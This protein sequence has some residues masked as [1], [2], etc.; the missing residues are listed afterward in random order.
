MTRTW[1]PRLLV[2]FFLIAFGAVAV[3]HAWLC[4]DAYIT[5]RTVDNF[6]N[7]Y[8][9]TWNVSERVQV[10]THPLWL[11]LLSAV[12]LFTREAF[13]SSQVLSIAVSLLAVAVLATRVAA[14]RAAACLGVAILAASKAFVDYATSG[15][16]N[17][18]THLILVA[19]FLVYFKSDSRP[20]TLFLLALLAASAML[21]RLDAGL[22]LLPPLVA[23]WARSRQARGLGAVAAGFVPLILWETFSF[24]YYGTLLPNTALAK[25]N[26]GLIGR[27][28]LLEQ[29]WHYLSDSIKVDPVTLSVI[30]AGLALPLARKAWRALP[31]SAGVVLYLVYIVRIGGDFM[32]GRFLTAPL[33][34]AVAI[35]VSGALRLRQEI[36]LATCVPLVVLVLRTP[37]SPLLTS[38]EYGADVP[39]ERWINPYGIAD[40]RAYY[41]PHTG[42]LMA[43]ERAGLP[44]HE[45]AMAGRAARL[46]GPAIVQDMAIGFLGYFAGPRVHVVD[47]LGLADPLLARLPPADPDWRIGHFLRM[48]PDGYV[49]TLT[50]GE[51]RIADENLA[52]YYDVLARVTRGDLFDV[53]RLVEAWKLNT[54]GYD[55]YLDA[56]AYF[57]GQAFTQRLLVTNPTDDP[58]V[59]AYVGNGET[60]EAI[61]LDETSRRGEVYAVR[62]TIAADGVRFEGPHVRPLSSMHTLSGGEPLNVGVYFSRR[63]EAPPHVTFER[64]FWFRVEEDRRL[65]IVLPGMEWRNLYGRPDT[66]FPADVGDVVR[67]AP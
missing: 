15:L 31:I 50:G 57:R 26:F 35:L 63:P 49:E 20:K 51:N 14:S 6:V 12:Y 46:K 47:Q 64:R 22:L 59:A 21:N 66:W 45:W 54:G 40:E 58:C 9:L 23:A 32:S 61:L 5:F 36:Y 2:L 52:A 44:D 39:P 41:Y 18:L 27:P 60:S 43:L 30:G 53:D 28:E 37:Y 4:D 13:F 33:V 34:A 29:G 38:P 62:W 8:G 1:G 55:H 17:P 56:Y 10:Y 3:R 67:D 42:L 7:G 19:F 65:V 25:L 16:E 48:V 24:F 11:M